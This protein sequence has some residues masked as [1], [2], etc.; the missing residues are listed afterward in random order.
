[1]SE[2]LKK[3]KEGPPTLLTDAGFVSFTELVAITDHMSLAGNIT[4]S[5]LQ[6]KTLVCTYLFKPRCTV[7]IRDVTLTHEG[8][9]LPANG[10]DVNS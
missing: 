7:L 1:M 10:L 6:K 3:P 4:L 5:Q 9:G 2:A 8:K